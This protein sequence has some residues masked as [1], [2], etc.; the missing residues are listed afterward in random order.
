[1]NRK[2][3]IAIVVQRYGEMIIGGAEQHARL[4]ALQ[5]RRFY[6]VDILTTT[7]LDS[8]AWLD[9]F[10]EGKTSIDGLAVHRF[11]IT[12]HPL[13][14]RIRKGFLRP[15]D[16]SDEY[17][18]TSLKAY[19]PSLLQWVCA[20]EYAYEAFVVFTYLFY[21]ANSVLRKLGHKCIFV[22]T[23]HDEPALYFPKIENTFRLA[24][25]ILYNSKA[26]RD[27]VERIFPNVARVPNEIVGLGFDAPRI[28]PNTST[29]NYSPYFLYA[30]RVDYGK[31]CEEL[32]RNFLAFLA[33]G[34]VHCKLVVIGSI[35]MKIKKSPEIIILG[36]VGDAERHALFAHCEA[37]IMPSPRES[38]S[39]ATLEAMLLGKPVIVNG[40]CEVL[41]DHVRGSKS[42][43][44]YE[45][46]AEF[47]AALLSVLKFSPKEK[48][49]NASRARR[50]VI[51]N[52]SWKKITRQYRT[53]IDKIKQ[54]PDA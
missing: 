34:N 33:E 50:Y 15:G 10:P 17:W 5:L 40:T 14:T 36:V 6:E 45:N 27:L 24:A 12:K 53:A 9:Y 52:Y 23:A 54:R 21:P 49:L 18:L 51:Q 30:G 32:F 46:Y 13:W 31:G 7:A 43:F 4:V 20:N 3:R 8:H 39:M 28:D 19:S 1:M 41:R 42:G 26:E 47:S 25:S 16:P 38:L 29:D 44:I 2:D 11:K 22:P 37:L 48:L 35:A